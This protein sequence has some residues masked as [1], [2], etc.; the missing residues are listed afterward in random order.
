M[1]FHKTALLIID[2]QKDVLKKLVNNGV[3]VV[4]KIQETLK[5]CREKGIPVVFLARV[6]RKDGID[7]EQ[8]RLQLFKEKPFLVEGT[9]GANLIDELRPLAPNT[10]S[11]KG[12]SAVFFKL[13]Y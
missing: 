12:G 6:H 1:G 9:Q 3:N 7:V 2:M 13:S 5:R 10:S 8:F 4:P 11:I